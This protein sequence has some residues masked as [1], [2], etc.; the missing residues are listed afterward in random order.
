MITDIQGKYAELYALAIQNINQEQRIVAAGH[1]YSIW[2]LARYK[3]DGTLDPTFGTGGIVQTQNGKRSVAGER[4]NALA[5]QPDNKIVAGGSLAG[6]GSFALA[7]YT[8]NGSLDATFGTGG[9]VVLKLDKKYGGSVEALAMQPDGKILACGSTGQFPVV[10]RLNPNGTL[11]GTFAAAGQFV[12]SGQR[13]AFSAIVI[14]VINGKK[15]LWPRVTTATLQCASH[16]RGPLTP[17][18][19]SAAS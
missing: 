5:I 8:V 17:V 13:G 3:P 15:G 1:S 10:V 7:R 9:K 4:I 14:Q 19:G 16:P 2:T 12:Y 6:G 11:D 18:S